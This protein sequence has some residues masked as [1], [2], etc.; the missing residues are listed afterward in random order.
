[1]SL[2]DARFIVTKEK[3]VDQPITVRRPSIGSLGLFYPGASGD[4]NVDAQQPMAA[5]VILEQGDRVRLA[6]TDHQARTHSRDYVRVVAG[7]DEAKPYEDVFVLLADLLI[8]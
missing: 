4:M 6:V 7:K 3:L 5:L 2:L 1:M 8:A